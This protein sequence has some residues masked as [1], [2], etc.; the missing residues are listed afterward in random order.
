MSFAPQQDRIL[1]SR[2]WLPDGEPVF[3]HI[4]H[5]QVVHRC[6]SLFPINFH[7]EQARRHGLEP[8]VVR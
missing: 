5:G 2:H 7:A 3:V 6:N 8:A 1:R 4:D